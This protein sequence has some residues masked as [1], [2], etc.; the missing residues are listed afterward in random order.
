MMT[1]VYPNGQR[2]VSSALTPTAISTLMQALTCGMIGVN[3]PDFSRVRLDWQ[4]TGQPAQPTP[5]TD[6]CYIICQPFDTDYSRVRDKVNSGTGPIVE[7]W[8]YTKGWRVLWCAYGPNSEDNMRAIKSA[9]FMDYFNLQLNAQ[10][11]YPLPDPP[12]VLRVPEEINKQ[13][14]ERAD[15]HCDMYEAVT[16]TIEYDAVSSVEIVVNENNTGQVADF[17]V[18]S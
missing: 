5:S 6:A 3:P 10:N 15:F 9:L 4:T 16:E 2:L 14:F 18:T 1:T 12:E 7:S 13:W 17:T 8:A 11:L